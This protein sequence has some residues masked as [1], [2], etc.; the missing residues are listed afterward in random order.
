MKLY[1]FENG[2]PV[3]YNG[4]PI[5]LHISNPTEEQLKFA[6]YKPI[7]EDEIPVFNEETQYLREVYTE[8]ATEIRR[9]YVVSEIGRVE[10]NEYGN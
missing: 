9:S 6:G 4:K 5:K 8:T 1:K 10:E 3:A 2:Q 7:V